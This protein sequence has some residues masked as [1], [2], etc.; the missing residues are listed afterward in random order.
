MENEKLCIKWNDFQ[1][2]LQSAFGKYRSGTDFSDVTL[3]CEGQII[4]AHKVIL[5]ACSPFFRNLL[6]SDL[7][8]QP[9][10]VMRGT[11]FSDL[12]SMLDFIYLGEANIFQEQVESF[13]A[14]AEELEL[15]GLAT[16]VAGTEASRSYYC[17]EDK[18]GLSG[19]KSNFGQSKNLSY[20][21]REKENNKNKSLISRADDKIKI[22]GDLLSTMNLRLR[23]D[24]QKQTIV[25][26]PSTL[27]VIDSLYQMSE[28]TYACK[29]CKYTN[30]NRAQ[31]RDHVQKHIEGLE[32]PCQVCNKVYRS[33]GA[34]RHHIRNPCIKEVKDEKL[35]INT[36]PEA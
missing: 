3:A 27:A 11:R 23:T 28:N 12:V 6:K 30:R 31:L 2:S 15:H 21:R 1:P 25:I 9:L 26:D 17:S 32:I 19:L 14:L 8:P 22:E 35:S 36:K 34:L 18:G 7:H 13:L 16:E 5:S 20:K 10:V 24:P 4:K 29:H 33:A